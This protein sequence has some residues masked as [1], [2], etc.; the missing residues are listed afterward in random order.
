M[1][2]VLGSGVLDGNL[3]GLAAVNFNSG[4]TVKVVGLNS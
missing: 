3:N 4:E 2:E 1:D